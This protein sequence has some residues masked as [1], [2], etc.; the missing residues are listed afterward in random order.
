MSI[1]VSIGGNDI[2]SCGSILLP[3]LSVKYAV[4]EKKKRADQI[5]IHGNHAKKT[6]VFY[7]SQIKVNRSV[8][9]VGKYGTPVLMA[10]NGSLFR[11]TGPGHQNIAVMISSITF[12]GTDH[13]DIQNSENVLIYL[14]NSSIS[15]RNCSFLSVPK[16]I[17]LICDV[18]CY[19]EFYYSRIVNPIIGIF[20]DGKG[21]VVTDVKKAEFIGKPGQSKQALTF[22]E[23]FRN[24]L[25]EVFVLSLT[26]C[27]FMYFRTAVLLYTRAV[28]C[29]IRIAYSLF[30][31][32]NNVG[33]TRLWECSSSVL[34]NSGY[35]SQS[36]KH[37]T[38]L[39]F[40][41]FSTFFLNNSALIGAGISLKVYNV[42]FHGT[43]EN[44]TF[45][46]NRAKAVG[47]A[48]RFFIDYPG[49]SFLYI[50]G[51]VFQNNIAENS[52]V[53]N[54][55]FLDM[56]SGS[57]GAISCASAK[58]EEGLLIGSLLSILSSTFTAN[59]AAI[60]GGAVY[61]FLAGVSL[62]NVNITTP[63]TNQHSIAHGAVISVTGI[64][65]LQRVSIKVNDGFQ[66]QKPV[67]RIN[68]RFYMDRGTIF[69][70]PVGSI[71]QKTSNNIPGFQE[72]FSLS[73]ISCDILKYNLHGST[74][75]NLRIY[76]P[77]CWE[78]PPGAI[79]QYGKL[80]PL[81]NYWGFVDN[82]TGNLTFVQ[83][84]VGYGCT[85]KQCNRYDSCAQNRKGTLCSTCIT[86]YSES[87][88]TPI[89]IQNE[90]CQRRE[91]WVLSAAI[92]VFYLLFFIYKKHVMCFLK[93][94][95]LW[96][97]SKN[98]RGN[99]NNHYTLNEDQYIRDR[100]EFAY[101]IQHGNVD[102]DFSAS[103]PPSDSAAGLLKI[104][105][106]FY[107]IE[108]LLEVYGGKTEVD[109]VENVKSFIK[110]VFNFNFL[111]SSGSSLCAMADTT[112][113][114]K[115]V[116]RG[117][118]VAAVLL[119][120]LIVYIIAIALERGV[121]RICKRSS[122]LDTRKQSFSD[123][124]LAALFEMFLLSYAIITN[125]I[126]SMLN[127]K[128]IGDRRVLYLQG[129]IQCFQSWQYGVAAAAFAW[130]VPFWLYISILP[131]LIKEKQVGTKG[132]FFGCIVP[133]PLIIY[134]LIQRKV[135]NKTV[136][137]SSQTIN[138]EGF[139]WEYVEGTGKEA[140]GSALD[141]DGKCQNAVV[142]AVQQMLCAPFKDKVN[143]SKY[144]SWDG[145][146]IFRRLF[147]ISAFVFV[148]D[149]IYKLYVIMAGQIIF[150]LH[151]AHI[152]PYKE[153]F[154]NHLE[155]ASL[156]MLVLINGM[157]LFVVY[158]FTH[159][160]SEVGD[161]RLLLQIFAWTENI[162]HLLVPAII[163]ASLGVLLIVRFLVVLFKMMRFIIRT[164]MRR[165]A[166]AYS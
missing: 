138:S 50:Q 129:D 110:N 23:Y 20:I 48:V 152:R 14:Q 160:I 53:K 102:D 96:F 145:V 111:K 74:F 140:C 146:Y 47:G 52:R 63:K 162:L 56:L 120:F 98:R 166:L 156:G 79:C 155:S 122:L 104:V 132:L 113:V 46:D 57:G 77:M 95:L 76:H 135:G 165:I 157:N 11:I 25:A 34:I 41:S 97:R 3:C 59:S 143:S 159:G 153:K 31:S 90:K 33:P 158:D 75:S 125:I 136:K 43:I 64:G 91:F 154:I 123:R 55:L 12:Q 44:C 124:V 6:A 45:K 24:S 35:Y 28:V 22:N 150:L 60:I 144:L 164:V 128:K 65:R 26:H 149:A 2:E 99:R 133:I 94:K 112:P 69:T 92:I 32:N 121:R 148:D 8:L 30:Q 115:V 61:T 9:L 4:M 27:K 83:L 39:S 70:C 119:A 67:I 161:K 71:I 118:F 78:C 1:H 141:D 108:A 101:E 87:M 38:T 21:K 66:S 84:P 85:S 134:Y 18:I 54:S 5:V 139:S 107:Q 142:F 126:I 86:G 89:C 40:A 88:F 13:K 137:N 103:D 147:I 37:S 105:F 114:T 16:P 15:I 73:C 51:S 17:A 10:K 106:Y 109:I 36:L 93:T 49:M 58:K 127:C 42:V 100:E 151:H 29:K 163:I 19:I 131:N 72:I 81:D 7:E 62:R 116:I 82:K 117:V 130:V 80:K 68:G